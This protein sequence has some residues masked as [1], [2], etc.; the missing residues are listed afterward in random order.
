MSLA[1][2]RIRLLVADAYRLRQRQRSDPN[3]QT[4]QDLVREAMAD[5]E[6]ILR[7]IADAARCEDTRAAAMV[8]VGSIRGARLGAPPG[9]SPEF[10]DGWDAAV[11]CV[12]ERLFG[13]ES[14]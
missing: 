13:V 1:M 2:A 14:A 6:M 10:L 4:A 8:F 5:L 7:S 12:A 3:R 9:E 11:G